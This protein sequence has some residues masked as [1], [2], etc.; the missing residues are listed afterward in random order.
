[1][2]IERLSVILELVSGAYKKEA[3]EAAAATASIGAAARTTSGGMVSLQSGMDFLRGAAVFAGASRIVAV[4]KDMGTA[5]AEDAQ[6][7]AVLA[8]A[9]RTNLAATDDMI[10]ANEEWITS[11]QVATNTA[12]TDLRQAITNLTVSGRSLEEAQKDIAI[13]MDVAASKGIELDSVIKGMV[14]SLATGS[15]AGLG[16]LGIE[17]KNAAGEMLTYDEVLK[18]AAET[19]GG[20]A[21]TAANTLAGAIERSRI[22]M[23]EAREEAGKNVIGPMAVLSGI[24]TEFQVQ[25]LGGDE[26]LARLNTTFNLLVSQGINPMTD[27]IAA[28]ITVLQQMNEVDLTPQTLN[29]LIAMLGLTETQVLELRGA[30]L[31]SED[32][33]WM[34]A[35]AVDNLNGLL[36]ELVGN[37]DP[38]VLATRRHQAAQQ[39]AARATRDHTGALQ[40]QRDLLR[41]MTDPLFALIAANERYEG[42]QRMLNDALVEGGTRSDEYQSALD[43][44]LRAQIDLTQAQADANVVGSDG[45]DLLR[46]YAIQAGI[47]MEAFDLWAQSV[48]NLAGS[49]S[50]LPSS[51]GTVNTINGNPNKP[52]VFHQGGVVPGPRGSDQ[53]IVAQGGEGILSLA[54]MSRMG[55]NVTKY[56][57]TINVARP[58]DN[59]RQD[60]QHATILASLTNLVEGL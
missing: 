59:F 51:I 53:L 15:T 29:T 34:E 56:G 54:Q 39:D 31:Q 46:Q 43:D 7:Q 20:A 22:V 27:Q 8:D 13:A 23:E 9:L 33:F 32:A 12:D 42:A 30:I 49:I 55:G 14:R 40:A 18:N 11:M 26:Q 45:L 17:T 60:L 58:M 24:W 3:K 38:A 48:N 25:L 21:A 2:A 37:T 4:L 36:D 52:G 57:P 16:R 1:M 41:E 6:S 47:N 5:A 19:M 50:N 35:A 10:A 44:L 28:A